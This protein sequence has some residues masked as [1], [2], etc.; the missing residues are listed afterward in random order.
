MNP[1]EPSSRRAP[2]PALG[3]KIQRC[4]R[5]VDIQ[6][7]LPPAEPEKHRAARRA[8]FAEQREFPLRVREI[9][10][11]VGVHAVAASVGL[12]AVVPHAAGH[13]PCLVTARIFCDY[14]IGS[15]RPVVRARDHRFQMRASGKKPGADPAVIPDGNLRE[16]IRG[17]AVQVERKL[18]AD[19]PRPHIIASLPN[20]LDA[21][22]SFDP[23]L[24]DHGATADEDLLVFHALDPREK[25]GNESRAGSGY[26]RMEDSGLRGHKMNFLGRAH[27]EPRDRNL[28]PIVALQPRV[29][30]ERA[31]QQVAAGIIADDFHR[32]KPAIVPCRQRAGSRIRKDEHPSAFLDHLD[33]EP[34][35]LLLAR[36]IARTNHDPAVAEIISRRK[37]HAGQGA[38][39]L[40][41]GLHARGGQLFP[42]AGAKLLL[43]LGKRDPGK[44]RFPRRRAE[45]IYAMRAAAQVRAQPENPLVR[46]ILDRLVGG[47]DRLKPIHRLILCDQAERAGGF[48]APAFFAEPFEEVREEQVAV[49]A[50]KK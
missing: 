45:F 8:A 32:L 24:L 36:P 23:E 21:P 30:V 6:V 47:R 17:C 37:I 14:A 38:E 48:G 44:P 42:S 27:V 33:D 11:A 46:G 50:A 35:V 25:L 29:E 16:R 28:E 18:L 49:G 19:I 9:M 7:V 34:Q 39:I 41:A 4:H 1:F 3:M 13:R 5:W 31:F 43:A 12:K 10:R 26:E 15:A 40:V 2:L 20:I 22:F